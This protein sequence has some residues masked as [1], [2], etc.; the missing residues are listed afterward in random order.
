MDT[1]L[2][3]GDKL[4]RLV[5]KI[6]DECSR[7]SETCSSDNIPVEQVRR[8]A[9]WVHSSSDSV[10]IT[11]LENAD[12]M[13]ESSRNSLLKLLEEPPDGCYFI[14]TTSRRGAVIPTILSRVR[15]YNF[16]NRSREEADEVI[17]RI[18]REEKGGWRSVREFFL[19]RKTDLE[20]C[21][22]FPR[23]LSR[24][25]LTAV[26]EIFFRRLE[27]FANRLTEKAIQTFFIEETTE[28][29][30]EMMA[31]GRIDSR[32]AEQLNALL[33]EALARRDQYNQSGQLVLESLL[34]SAAEKL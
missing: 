34:Y 14:L 13:Q 1:E 8:I 18:F 15:G 2:P 20:S 27:I 23:P 17:R 32:R 25:Q 10:K 26:G 29:L 3:S 6:V 24:P 12:M 5:N 30:R 4:S 11:I 16:R 7:I 31:A 22:P 28:R 21:V 9:S 33:R 19:G